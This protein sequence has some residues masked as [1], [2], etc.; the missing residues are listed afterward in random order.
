MNERLEELYGGNQGVNSEV[1]EDVHYEWGTKDDSE[2]RY[3]LG[4]KQR[5]AVQEDDGERVIG[6]DYFGLA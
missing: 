6:H 1:S 4:L 5:P 2:R 3:D